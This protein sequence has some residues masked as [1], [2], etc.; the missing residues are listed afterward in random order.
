MG[1]RAVYSSL[2]VS[3]SNWRR[4]ICHLGVICRE[5]QQHRAGSWGQVVP[6]NPS[7]RAP[8]T[9]VPRVLRCLIVTTIGVT[10]PGSSVADTSEAVPADSAGTLPTLHASPKISPPDASSPFPKRRISV[11]ASI[12]PSHASPGRREARSEYTQGR[13]AN[14]GHPGWANNH[15]TEERCGALSFV[16]RFPNSTKRLPLIPV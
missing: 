15:I 10:R 1:A 7:F 16:V 4:L 2:I 11:A 5:Q 6:G 3:G 8:Q 14:V 13:F 9:R 12:R